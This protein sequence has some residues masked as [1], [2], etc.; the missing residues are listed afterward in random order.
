MR[1]KSL[2]FRNGFLAPDDAVICRDDLAYSF[3][4]GEWVSIVRV[5]PI[6]LEPGPGM[7]LLTGP[8]AD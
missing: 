2:I 6:V 1:I 8:E 7:T 3:G 5:N 4:P